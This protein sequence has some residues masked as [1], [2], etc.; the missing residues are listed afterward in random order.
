MRHMRN[1]Q[2]FEAYKGV[3]RF[4]H[5]C[6]PHHPLLSLYPSW[7]TSF[8]FSRFLASSPSTRP[9]SCSVFSSSRHECQI[10]L[11]QGMFVTF[12]GIRCQFLRLPAL[13]NSSSQNSREF[14]LSG[15]STGI[16]FIFLSYPF[17]F[18]RFSFVIKYHYE[19]LWSIVNHTLKLLLKQPSWTVIIFPFRFVTSPCSALICVNK[20]FL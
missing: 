18:F 4:R 2:R 8:G 15:R 13:G 11:G 12:T 9:F 5:L 6:D 10:H 14:F 1:G 3:S 7:F 16:S 17:W 19:T 20:C